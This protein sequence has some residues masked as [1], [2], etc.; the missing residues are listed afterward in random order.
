MISRS[1]LHKCRKFFTG[2]PCHKKYQTPFFLIKQKSEGEVL[3]AFSSNSQNCR[4]ISTRVSMYRHYN[5]SKTVP[6]N[7]DAIK[8]RNEWRDECLQICKFY[9]EC[10][11][12]LSLCPQTFISF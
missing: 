6:K 4:L 7:L 5:G 10:M 8:Q 1:D 12:K 3:H 9:K 11:S 2:L